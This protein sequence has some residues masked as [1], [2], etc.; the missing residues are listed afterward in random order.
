M[1][2]IVENTLPPELCFFFFFQ[3]NEREKFSCDLFF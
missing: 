1:S 2:L 3:K